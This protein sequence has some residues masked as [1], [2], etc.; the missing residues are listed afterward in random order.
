M[1]KDKSVNF[2]NIPIEYEFSYKID[3]LFLH[4]KAKYG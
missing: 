3:A 2:R 4:N 1:R